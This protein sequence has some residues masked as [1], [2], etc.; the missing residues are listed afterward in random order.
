M[1]NHDVV[2]DRIVRL[3][4]PLLLMRM[5]VCCWAF[6]NNPI[7]LPSHRLSLTGVHSSS[8]STGSYS[9]ER[10]LHIT[11]SPSVERIS[12]KTQEHR[13]TGE[14][15]YSGLELW[16]DLRG[17]S[18]TPK[19]AL[20]LW[21]MEGQKENMYAPPFVKCLVSSMEMSYSSPSLDR[22]D[23]IDVLIVEERMDDDDDM[24]YI[25][26]QQL[27]DPSPSSSSS[28]YCLGRILNLHASSS[29]KPMLP[30]PLLAMEHASNGQWIII[31]TD[32]WKK[33]EADERLRMSL[34]LL[35]LI[36]SSSAATAA[37][38]KK[39]AGNNRGGIGLTCHTNN[40]VVKTIMFIQSMMAGGG[41]DGR[42]VRTKTLTSGI[43]IP[44][45]DNT[46]I[47]S[48][49]ANDESTTHHFAIVVPYD[50]ELLRTAQLL[51]GK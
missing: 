26:Q 4:A 23:D 3:V 51:L 31:D 24:Q 46:S 18:L 30:D 32:G 11:K 39:C 35:E 5:M 2:R 29:S 40:E 25:T 9:E 1:M 7:S 48:A 16:L 38:T 17:S 19:T 13:F 50:I 12:R 27:Y 41:G 43:V 8:T 14:Y 6:I 21:A 15:E 42:Q 37:S 28:N 10:I 20:Q 33:I 22:Y 34:P 36:A 45:E 44:D 47:P 49:G